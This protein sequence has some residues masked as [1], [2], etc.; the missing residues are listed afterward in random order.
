MEKYLDSNELNQV[1]C[2]LAPEFRIMAPAYEHLGGRFA[3]TDNLLYQP[4]NQIDQIVWNKKSHF[5]PKEV[6][7]PITETLFYFNANELRESKVEARPTLLFLR[8]CD[9]HA[10]ERLDYMYLQNGGNADYYYQA[11]RKKLKLV[12]L[13]CQSSFENCFCVSMGTNETDQ[14]DAAIR[15]DG[16]N[17]AYLNIK[18]TSLQPYFDSLGINC[19]YQPQFVQSNPTSVRTPDQVCDDPALI[20]QILQN[21]PSWAEYNSRCIGCGRCTTSCPT[22]SC[23][24]VFDI[25]YDEN[26][27]MGERRRQQASCMT[28][29]FTDMAGGHKFRQK[30]GERLR[31]RA[32]HKVNDYKARQGN[33]HMCVGCGRCDDRCPQ[34]ISFTNIINR[35]TDIVEHHIATQHQEQENA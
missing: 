7:L 33:H 10:L 2:A 17:G 22:C 20:R 6:V 16:N 8:A 19:D 24:N 23:Y 15:F 4:I 9:I 1:F 32:L 34:Y 27:Q 3:H 13:E 11:K 21:D 14:F 31:Y 28:D 30:T 26:P 25:A 35:M 5:S 29:N 12:L 18:D